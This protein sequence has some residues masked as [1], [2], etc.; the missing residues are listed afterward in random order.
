MNMNAIWKGVYIGAAIGSA[1]F[2]VMKTTG[3]KKKNIRKDAVKTLK[4]AKNLMDDI[5]SV[6]M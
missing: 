2:M 1:A 3:N 4:S 5:S 6:V